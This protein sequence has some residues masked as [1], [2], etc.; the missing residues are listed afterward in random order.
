MGPPLR[1]VVVNSPASNGVCSLVIGVETPR[2]VSELWHDKGETDVLTLAEEPLDIPLLEF[3]TRKH[4]MRCF[5]SPSVQ[6][7]KAHSWCC[8]QPR[9]NHGNAGSWLVF[10][11]GALLTKLPIADP[12]K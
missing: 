1:S 8:L 6:V 11:S 4:A 12:L 3:S 9:L 7:H 10:P 2:S 5:L